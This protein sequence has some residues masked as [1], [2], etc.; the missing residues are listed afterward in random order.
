[1]TEVLLPATTAAVRR[2]GARMLKRYS[3]EARAA[4]LDDLLAALRANDEAVVDVL[5]PALAEVLPGAVCLSDEH[6]SGSS[7]AGDWSLIDPVGGNV[8]AVHGMTD[9]NIGVSLVRD[10]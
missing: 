9:W 6:V 7:A 4:G 8:N 5:Q 2:A 3:T 10:G 1:M